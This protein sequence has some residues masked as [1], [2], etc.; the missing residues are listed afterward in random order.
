MIQQWLEDGLVELCGRASKTAQSR[1]VSD[2]F[3]QLPEPD[4]DLGNAL[5]DKRV[6]GG[7]SQGL[8][9]DLVCRLPVLFGFG[10]S[11]RL[12]EG[13]E[14]GWPGLGEGRGRRVGG[15]IEFWN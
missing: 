7:H 12:A 15:R 11:G 8:E 13:R 10:L 2:G 1:Q 6:P 14:V 4:L 3:A 9:I 5:V